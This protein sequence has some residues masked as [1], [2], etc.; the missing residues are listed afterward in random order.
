MSVKRADKKTVCRSSPVLVDDIIFDVVWLRRC[1]DTQLFCLSTAPNSVSVWMTIT[2]Q[3]NSCWNSVVVHL[4]ERAQP[5][6]SQ[7]LGER[8]SW[9]DPVLSPPTD[10]RWCRWL[11]VLN[12]TH[13]ALKDLAEPFHGAKHFE[14]SQETARD[15]TSLE[16]TVNNWF[17]PGRRL[18]FPPISTECWGGD[19][20]ADSYL[21]HFGKVGGSIICRCGIVPEETGRR[22]QLLLRNTHWFSATGWHGFECLN[23]QRTPATF[24]SRVWGQSVLPFHSWVMGGW[25]RETQCWHFQT[26]QTRLW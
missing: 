3:A 5:P 2:W 9:G 23:R 16:R 1:T 26:C 21:Q 13:V 25:G 18:R 12:V 10:L 4:Y 15:G 22:W 8:S 20:I 7:R 14:S 6:R 17:G 24:T 11:L 19:S